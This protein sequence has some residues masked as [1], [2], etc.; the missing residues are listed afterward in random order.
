M[1][2]K[3]PKKLK[4]FIGMDVHQSMTSICVLNAKG[5][6]YDAGCVPTKEQHLREYLQSLPPSKGLVIEE[7]ELAQWL[8][9][10][11]PQEVDEMVVC[12][13]YRNKCLQDGPKNDR[14]DALK[15]AQ[16]Y[17]VGLIRIVYH[18][19]HKGMEVRKLASCYRATMKSYVRALC[20]AGAFGRQRG[21]SQ[22]RLSPLERQVE[23]LHEQ[24]VQFFRHQIT[25]LRQSIEKNNQSY[26]AVRYIKSV[27]GIGPIGAM[28]LLATVVDPVRFVNKHQFWSYCGL[29]KHRRESA[30]KSYGRKKARANRDLK[31]VFKTAAITSLKGEGPMK[32][33]FLHLREKGV[34]ENNARHAVSRKV[35]ACVLYCWKHQKRYDPNFERNRKIGKS[36]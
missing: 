26:L 30:G 3:I 13:P 21:D 25:V 19:T 24:Q 17:R 36:S 8:Y 15:L 9:T 4:Y 18:S 27:P 29:V 11:L 35:A 10:I 2:T 20:Q 31:D 23:D 22:R 5:E 6:V 34:S 32:Q 1:K 14:I 12:D 28:K 7:M 16:L 33:Y